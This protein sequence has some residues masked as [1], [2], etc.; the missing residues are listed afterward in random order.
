MALQR[1][2]AQYFDN[3]K[4]IRLMTRVS[5]ATGTL[6]RMTTVSGLRVTRRHVRVTKK[7]DRS[8]RTRGLSGPLPA[9][10]RGPDVATSFWVYCKYN[11]VRPPA[12]WQM[13]NPPF[14]GTVTMKVWDPDYKDLM[15][16]IWELRKRGWTQTMIEKLLGKPGW[17]GSGWGDRSKRAY[18]VAHVEAVEADSLFR[19]LF[20]ASARRRTLDETFVGE[21]LTR[22]RALEQSGAIVVWQERSEAMRIAHEREANQAIPKPPPP[23]SE[24]VCCV[25]V[26]TTVDDWTTI[27]RFVRHG[28][29]DRVYCDEKPSM[30]AERETRGTATEAVAALLPGVLSTL[31]RFGGPVKFAGPGLV[32]AEMFA[33]VG[34]ELTIR[35]AKAQESNL[36]QGD[37]AIV[38]LARKLGLAPEPSS[39]ASGIWDAQCPGGRHRLLL[40][41]SRNE[42]WC[43]YCNRSGDLDC[44]RSFA[45]DRKKTSLTP[46]EPS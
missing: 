42:F 3:G 46:N 30:K 34:D 9:Q 43:G 39:V 24:I 7:D 26:V 1:S 10:L 22:S 28:G 14:N 20:L 36:E 4:T 21:V 18:R 11:R 16:D 13:G 40:N 27:I 5:Q 45:D 23:P 38:T 33:E 37:V 44:L 35:W 12:K 32:D 19:E 17:I 15:M 8:Y 2:Y 29:M 25:D 41:T 31:M 6:R